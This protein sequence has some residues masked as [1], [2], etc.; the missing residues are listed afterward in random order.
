MTSQQCHDIAPVPGRIV[1]RLAPTR[2]GALRCAAMPDHTSPLPSLDA[3]LRSPEAAVLAD[4][5]GRHAAPGA[6]RAVLAARRAARRFDA[7]PSAILDEAADALARQF[8][9]SQRPVFNLTGTV[10]HTNLGRAP[11][12]PEAAEA[13]AAAMR[14]AT[15]LEFDL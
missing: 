9:A 4:R 2:D 8:A 10:L 1:A 14:S 5:F 11:L 3:L 7:P 15:T 13:A 12:P 6:L